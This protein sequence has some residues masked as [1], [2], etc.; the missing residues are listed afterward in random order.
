MFTESYYLPVV[1]KLVQ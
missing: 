1:K